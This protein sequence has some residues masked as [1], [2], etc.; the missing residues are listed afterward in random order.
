MRTYDAATNDY[1][2]TAAG[3]RYYRDVRISY[4]VKVPAT[5]SGTR[6]NGAAYTRNGHYPLSNPVQLRA[7]LTQQQ[8]DDQVRREVAQQYPNGVLSEVS[9]ERVIIRPGGAWFVA[10]MVTTGPVVVGGDPDTNVIV[11]QLGMKPVLTQ[12]PFPEA[13]CSLAFENH[14]GKM[15]CPRQLAAILKESEETVCETLDSIRDW[16]AGGCTAKQ[17]FEFCRRRGLGC[18]ALHG[19]RVIETLPARRQ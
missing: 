3:R 2:Y 9:E 4:V 12:L 19:D 13:I 1:R 14:P 7:T 5:F 10:E 6:S 15:C 18:T 8:R 17:I 11:R 16:R